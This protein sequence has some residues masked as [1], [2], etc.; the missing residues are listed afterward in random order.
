MEALEQLKA[1]KV[2]DRPLEFITA[3]PGRRYGEFEPIL[4]AL[5]EDAEQDLANVKDEVTG[6]TGWQDDRLIWA[7]SPRMAEQ[8]NQA[9][10]EKIKAIED[11]AARRV[12]KLDGQD[13]GKKHRGRKLS[14]SGA[15]AWMYSELKEARLG[16]IIKVD[17]QSDLFSYQIDEKAL[18]LAELNDGKLLLV[19]N[20]SDLTPPEVVARYKALGHLD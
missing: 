16:K 6:E 5:H 13:T 4:S 3:V 14:D 8:A 9:R 7:H 17:L 19:T 20:V 18:K 1:L 11:G 12:N 10:Q 15:K 2:K